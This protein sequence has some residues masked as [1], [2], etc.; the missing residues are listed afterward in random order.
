MIREFKDSSG[1][2]PTLQPSSPQCTDR[3]SGR[4]LLVW[5]NQPFLQGLDVGLAINVSKDKLHFRVN[6]C[7][8]VARK[9]TVPACAK[10]LS[11][12]RRHNRN[13]NFADKKTVPVLESEEATDRTQQ[14]KL[15]LSE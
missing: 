12:A 10:P 9:N 15:R 14:I 7:P 3:N 2:V 5:F 4:D 1:F 11:C 13:L 6:L 8:S